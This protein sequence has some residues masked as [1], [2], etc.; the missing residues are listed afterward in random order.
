M[1][2]KKR[3][4][5]YSFHYIP[6]SWRVSQIRNIGAIEGNKPATDND[7]ETI[8]NAGDAQIKKWI[9]EQMKYRSCTVVLIGENTA[10]R[11]WINYEIIQSWNKGMG[12]V[13]IYIN[14]LK[15]VEGYISNKG[16]N[17]FDY[18]TFGNSKNK[19]STKIKCYTP[20]GGTSREKY[21]WISNNLSVA[22]EEAINI[23]ENN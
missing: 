12:V 17:P 18:I 8:V 21:N 3:Q 22:V 9:N 19:L 6:D 15:N 23:R 14:G 10:N 4:I 20:L 7:W 11:K 1:L 2:D 16:K 13:G 5:F